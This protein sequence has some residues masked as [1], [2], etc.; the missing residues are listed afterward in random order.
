MPVS[1]QRVWHAALQDHE[2][3]F[4]SSGIFAVCAKI[5]FHAPSPGSPGVRSR[6]LIGYRDPRD[7]GKVIPQLPGIV[8]HNKVTG[9]VV[10][11]SEDCATYGLSPKKETPLS[12]RTFFQK[13]ARQDKLASKISRFRQKRR[14][15]HQASYLI[16][17]RALDPDRFRRHGSCGA[18][19]PGANSDTGCRAL[20]DRCAS[21]RLS[22]RADPSA[23]ARGCRDRWSPLYRRFSRVSFLFS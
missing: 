8:S 12:A 15:I 5:H 9:Y 4:C 1:R 6:I 21:A 10:P 11:S 7:N 19:A 2:Q 20:S 3:C 18:G 13:R 17:E 23:W 22:K 14:D 16:P